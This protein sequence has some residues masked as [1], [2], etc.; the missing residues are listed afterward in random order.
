MAPPSRRAAK[1]AFNYPLI[2]INKNKFVFFAPAPEPDTAEAGSFTGSS[3]RPGIKNQIF[4]S[5]NLNI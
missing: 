5:A 3:E 2:I 1:S 4:S